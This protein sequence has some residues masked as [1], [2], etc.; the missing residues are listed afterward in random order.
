VRIKLETEAKLGIQE[1][2]VQGKL[3]LAWSF[4]LDFENQ[5]NPFEQR[6]LAIKDWKVHAFVYTG[7]TKEILETAERFE[8]MGIRGKDALHVACAVAMKCDY[9]LTTDD[10]LVK[11][12]SGATE[13][14]VTD[15][16]SF[17]REVIE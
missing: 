8:R 16:V 7:S 2:I 14:K 6:K 4:I 9:F 1:R 11:K 15:P 5:A 13:I 10:H 17:I 3:K 12:A